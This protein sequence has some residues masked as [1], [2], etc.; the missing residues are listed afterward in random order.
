MAAAVAMYRPK[1]VASASLGRAILSG[2]VD[3]KAR[4]PGRSSN[5]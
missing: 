3:D 2:T 5:R 1:I 4:K